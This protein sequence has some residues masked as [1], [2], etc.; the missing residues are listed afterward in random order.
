MDILN[1][2]KRP[3]T[4]IKNLVIGLVVSY[5]PILNIIT[6]GYFVRCAR[7]TMHGKNTLP[8]WIGIK[9]LLKDMLSAFFISLSY[10]IIPIG[11]LL[12][13]NFNLENFDQLLGMLLTFSI[14]DLISAL[15]TLEPLYPV[16]FLLWGLLTVLASLLIP[17]SIM[18]FIEFGRIDKPFMIRV[19]EVLKK[20]A[21]SNYLIA[22][23]LV[24]IGSAI[25]R[26]I[27]SFVPFV[28]SAISS[29]LIGVI[30][31]TIFAQVYLKLRQ[32][33]QVSSGAV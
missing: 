16:L 5:I 20:A 21:T 29:F 26:W 17:I 31:F 7:S 24:F 9:D 27:F 14:R 3:F 10:L 33:E 11:I 18:R 15:S 28:G 25:L 30:S 13:L 8:D 1:A 2:L 12:F 23:V 4:N 6:L 32:K 19:R 22:F